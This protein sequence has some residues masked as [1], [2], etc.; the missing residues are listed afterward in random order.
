M[1]Q[2]DLQGA[3]QPKAFCDAVIFS[4]FQKDSEI[5]VPHVHQ[6]LPDP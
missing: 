2:N 5:G 1:Q 6:L 3:F 4:G